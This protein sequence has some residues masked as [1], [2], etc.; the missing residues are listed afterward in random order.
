M[1]RKAFFDTIRRRG[2]GVFGTALSQ[3]Q[4]D[5]CNTLL[6]ATAHVTL[7]HRAYLLATAYHETARSMLPIKETV[8]PHHKDKNPSD[9]TVI[10]RLDA[11][12]AKGQMPQVKSA[13][14]RRD[15]DGRAW[16]GRGYVQ[17]THRTNYAKA[18][19]ALGVDLVGNPSLAMQPDIAA[20]ILVRG[21]LEGWFT[22]KR[23][24]DFQPR[25][26]A[27]MRRV[28]NGTDRAE[29]IAGYARAFEAA[30]LAM[31]QDDDAPMASPAVVHQAGNPKPAPREAVAPVAA[32][33]AP[34]MAG[35]LW[36]RLLRALWGIITGK[37]H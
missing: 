9:A 32:P 34:D 18:G 14:W 3:G 1:N 7:T 19:Q 22:G 36:L 2:S 25:D 15:S 23:L 28:V 21:C 30:I 12:W 33:A 13:Y 5:G 6:D 11:A 29:Q 26:Y 35:P 37:G 16:F 27:G 8:M 10:A 20:R 31:M 4:V 24:G 17:L